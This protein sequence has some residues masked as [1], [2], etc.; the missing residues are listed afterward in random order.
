MTQASSSSSGARRGLSRGAGRRA[1]GRLEAG[2]EH[3]R[4]VGLVE[5]QTG[6]LVGVV[7]VDR[8]VGRADGEDAEDGD[9]EL[10][11]PRRDAHA[12]PV[13][14]AHPLAGQPVGDAGRRRPR[15]RGR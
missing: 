11:G 15:G 14:A 2:A 8:H 13:A 1:A 12:H 9:V 7:V 4:H 3:D 6:P 5:D 10:D